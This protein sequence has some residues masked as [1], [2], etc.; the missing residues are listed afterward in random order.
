M[1]FLKVTWSKDHT[2]RLW[3]VHQSIQNQC[4]K[5]ETSADD[6][7]ICGSNDDSPSCNQDENE[8]NQPL[9]KPQGC[10]DYSLFR[11]VCS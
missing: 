2:L 10:E 1:V 8:Q 9:E 6:T 5:G 11:C 4:G 3:Q 7:L